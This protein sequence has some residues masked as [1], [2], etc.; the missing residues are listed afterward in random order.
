[1]KR[2]LYLILAVLGAICPYY[3]FIPFI[4]ENGLD[5]ELFVDQLFVNKISSFFGM[6]VIVSMLV[7]IAFVLFE[8]KRIGMRNLGV[9]MIATVTVGVSFGLPLFLYFR[10]RY[11]QKI[12]GI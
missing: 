12:N 8:G 11:V 10:E 9:Y 2:N 6:D 7:L 1:M 3:Y 4:F 5:V